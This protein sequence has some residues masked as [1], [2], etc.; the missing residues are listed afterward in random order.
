LGS[1]RRGFAAF[2]LLYYTMILL[3]YLTYALG[4]PVEVSLLESA[5]QGG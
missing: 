4:R 1:L 5:K 2:L 3:R